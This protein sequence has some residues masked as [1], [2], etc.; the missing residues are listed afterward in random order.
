MRTA[1]AA[2]ILLALGAARSLEPTP[3]ELLAQDAKAFLDALDPLQREMARA[4]IDAPARTAWSFVPGERPGIRLDALQPEQRERALSMARRA[5]SDHGWKVVRGVFALEGML[6]VGQ[7]ERYN[8][9]WYDML[10]FGDPM[11]PPWGMRLEGHHL[12]LHIMSDGAQV[13][14]TPMFVGVAP[15]TVRGGE[16]DGFSPLGRERELAFALWG[17]LTPEQRAKARLAADAPMDVFGVPGGESRLKDRA[18]LEAMHMTREQRDA[19]WALVRAFAAR[20]APAIEKS[21]VARWRTASV[22]AMVFA[23]MGGDE[24]T[25]RHYFRIVGDGFAIEFDCTSGVDHVHSVWHDL[26]RNFGDPFLQH[27]KEHAAGTAH[28]HP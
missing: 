18:G 16:L 28:K 8:P 2:S 11:T 17:M 19:L 6:G 5:L 15:F 27:A 25:Q 7:P 24:P 22:D 1:F 20:L 9:L 12:S 23:W 14:V 26:H 21:E 3:A 13:T 10:V 4:S